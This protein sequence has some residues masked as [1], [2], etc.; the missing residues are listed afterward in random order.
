MGQRRSGADTLAF[1]S[2]HQGISGHFVRK[3]SVRVRGNADLFFLS[4]TLQGGLSRPT[5]TKII[6]GHINALLL[7]VLSQHHTVSLQEQ[8]TVK[9]KPNFG[10]PS[11][12]RY[13]SQCATP[14]KDG[15]GA[16]A[17]FGGAE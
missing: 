4:A 13:A 16:P 15:S 7:W 10:R 6:D 5:I 1:I 11:R 12:L 9:R 8:I 17:V 2:F 3:L 14:W